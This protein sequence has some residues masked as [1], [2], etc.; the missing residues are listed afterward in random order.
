MSGRTSHRAT[1]AEEKRDIPIGKEIAERLVASLREREAGPKDPL[2]VNQ[3]GHRYNR[4][5]LYEM[6]SR[7]AKRAGIERCKVGPH[8]LRHTYNYV[9]RTVAKLDTTTRSGL[10]NHSDLNTLRSYEHTLPEELFE[11]R[12]RVREGMKV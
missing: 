4:S 3:V 6:V 2:L 5:S 12:E 9:A 10:L 8:T 7:V 1:G 11:A